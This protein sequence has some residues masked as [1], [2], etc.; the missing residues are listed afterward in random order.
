M[1]LSSSRHADKT[2]FFELS[3]PSIAINHPSGQVLFGRHPVSAQMMNVCFL[4]VGQNWCAIVRERRFRVRPYFTNNFQHVLLW[5]VGQ[6][7]AAASMIFQN[8]MQRSFVVSVEIFSLD[9]SLESERCSHSIVLTRLQLGRIDVL[10]YEKSDLVC[11]FSV[12]LFNGTSTF[13]YYLMP[14]PSL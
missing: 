10:F 9:V 11:L 3:S 13:A 8:S 2:N 7:G 5:M 4:L 12:S 14:K 1:L 6:K